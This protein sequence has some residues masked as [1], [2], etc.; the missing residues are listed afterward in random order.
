[1]KN[2]AS[3]KNAL[4]DEV[5]ILKK[6]SHPNIIKIQEVFDTEKTLYI[7]LELYVFLTKILICSV[8]GG[9]LFDTIVESG[10]IEEEKAKPLI[11]QLLDAVHYLHGRGIVHRDLKVQNICQS[12]NESP[13][14]FSSL[15]KS[16]MN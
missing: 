11:K 15:L 4:M 12:S 10:K 8:T 14:I 16:T 1:M 7:V 13:K 9:E 6:I 3:R 2:A 5:D